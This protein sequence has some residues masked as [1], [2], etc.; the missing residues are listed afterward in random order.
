[1]RIVIDMQGAQTESRFRG[2][3]RYT[4]SFIQAVA[5]NK[6]NH[7]VILALNGLFP[8]TIEPIRLAFSD[9]IPQEDIRVWQAPGPV[10]DIDPD[11]HQRRTT[12][13]LIRETFLFNLR[14]DIIHIC[15]LFEG[16]VDDA[17]TSIGSIDLQTPVSVSLYDLIPLLNPDQYLNSNTSYAQ[18]YDQKLEHL[19]RAAAYLCISDYTRQEGLQYLDSSGAPFI[20]VSTAIEPIFKPLKSDPNIA[21]QLSQ[22]IGISRPFIL[23][24][25]G[26]DERKNLP[27]LIQAFAALPSTLREQYHLVL[28]G[29]T[30]DG[31]TKELQQQAHNLGLKADDLCFTGYVSDETLVQLYNFCHLFVFPSWHEGF[32]LPVLEAMACGAPA[33]AADAASIPE[34]IGWSEALF[35]PMSVESISAKIIQ[36]L[37]DDAFRQ[38]LRSH[39]IERAGR[40]SWD[41]TGKRALATWE[42]MRQKMEPRQPSPLKK[43]RLAFVSPLPPERTGIADHSAG[44]LPVLAQHYDIELVVDQP[45]VDHSCIPEDCKIRDIAWLR[46]NHR[47]IDRVLYQMGNS[48]YH[49]HM[50]GLIQDIPGTVVLHDFFLSSL[51]R[52]LELQAGE[53]N[54]WT[55]ALYDSHGYP[56]LRDRFESSAIAEHKYPV[57][58]NIFQHAQGIIVHS[59]HAKNLGEQWWPGICKDW[60]VIPL[61]RTPATLGNKALARQRLNINST[62]YLVCSFGFLHE[63]KLNLELLSAWLTSKLANNQDCHLI[64]VGENHCGTYGTL[65]Q[66]KIKQSGIAERIHI[67]GYV[68]PELYQTYLQAA[69]SAVQLRKGSRGETSAAVL[70]CMNYGL[71]TVVNAHGSLAELDSKAVYMLPEV[72]DEGT[73]VGALELLRFD[74]SLRKSLAENAKAVLQMAHEPKKCAAAYAKAIESFHETSPIAATTLVEA[75][76]QQ[77]NYSPSSKDLQAVA[78]AITINSPLVNPKPRILLDI[79][80]TRSTDLRTGIERVTRA[81]TLELLSS[82]PA[83]YRVEPVYLS[84]TDGV[85]RHRFARQYTLGLLKC[86]AEVLDDDFVDPAPGDFLITLDLSG[87]QL[88]EAQEQGLFRQYQNIGVRC[89][90]TVFDLLPINQP[91]VFPPDADLSHERWLKSISTLDGAVCIS[92]AVASELKAWQAKACIGYDNRRPFHVTWIH[93]GA[94]IEHSAPT[95]GMPELHASVLPALG[96]RPSFLM[97]GTIEPRKGLLQTIKAFSELWACGNDINLVIVGKEGWR[98]LP[99]ELRRDI[100]ETINAITEHKEL[101]QR[102]FWL[103]EISDQYLAEIYKNCACLI[104]ASYGEGFGLPL[105]EAARYKLPII[106]RDI[107]IFREV[108]GDHAFYFDGIDSSKLM[109]SV[110][111]WMKLHGEGRHPMSEKIDSLTWKQSANQLLTSLQITSSFEILKP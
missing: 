14:P 43:L 69:D 67:T 91:H 3:G 39:G 21:T 19:R 94:D 111:Q 103:N 13:E 57:N 72:C 74:V 51:Y 32:G 110:A 22:R 77:D 25:G 1:M 48:P 101:G 30:T 56:S 86:P 29:K 34:V 85:W 20:N 10:R 90:A 12:S 81:L 109:K 71:P 82:P 15:S 63:T 60:E 18:Y 45:L 36:G 76:A 9:L 84:E 83:N 23:Y 102:L 107:P 41:V 49:R 7:Q 100:P 33:I 87:H 54:A 68:S 38:R 66:N 6:E 59:A 47:K 104:A 106:A 78:Y 61:L 52:W 40:F 92:R 8:D 75:I 105:I 80:A 28:A 37:T 96:M 4:M 50:L 44:L 99:D 95:Q 97:V 108:A 42:R 2:I 88:I 17:I 62:D 73:L 58:L 46:T 35:D 27:R 16:Y 89:Y 53:R 64:F 70:D 24:T 31:H 55:Q 79:S 26:P 98:Q 93:L 11:N 65:L 5:R